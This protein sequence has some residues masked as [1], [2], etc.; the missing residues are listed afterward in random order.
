MKLR[1]AGGS[2]RFRLTR[3]EV[4]SLAASGRISESLNF[5]SG[6]TLSYSLE[7]ASVL[8]PE[9]AFIGDLIRVLLPAP[10]VKAWAES[11][12]TAILS[13][14]RPSILVE[15]DFRCIHHP[16]DNADKFPNPAAQDQ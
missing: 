6:R 15:K 11:E 4:A 12:E 2:L 13:D 9:A 7:S 3:S 5:P 1:I 14:A 10:Q 16:D 8:A